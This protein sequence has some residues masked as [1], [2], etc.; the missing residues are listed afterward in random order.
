[1][2]RITF[3]AFRYSPAIGGAENYLRRLLHELRGSID[4]DVLTLVTDQRT[5]WL[6]AMID[7]DRNSPRRYE[8]D[9]REVV[10]LGRWPASTRQALWALAPAY[11][12]PASP[13]PWRMGTMLAP[14]LQPHL[15]RANLVHNVFMG[16]EAFSAGLLI[17]T[18]KA[19]VPFVFTPLRRGADRAMSGPGRGRG[20]AWRAWWAGGSFDSSTGAIVQSPSLTSSAW[21]DLK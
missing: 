4:A 6:R 8:V 15:A 1:M 13:A 12:L 5:D 21:A 9:G 16:R 11:H 2:K 10:A 7:G 17:A 19:G 18:R 3:A 14:S 20:D